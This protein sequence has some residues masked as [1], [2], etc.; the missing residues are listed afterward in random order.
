MAKLGEFEFLVLL[1]ILKTGDQ[2][3]VNQVRTELEAGSRRSV[4][5]GALYHTLDRLREKGLVTWTVTESD[6][7]QRG[8]HPMRK[9]S[10]TAAGLTAAR[11]SRATLA[12]FLDGLDEV[13]EV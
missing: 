5:R 9:L 2:P 6:V 1:A 7:P 3:F 11:E 12:Y 13:L 4:S 8:G 10:V